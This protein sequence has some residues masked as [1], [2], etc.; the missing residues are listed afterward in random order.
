MDDFNVEIKTL[1]SEELIKELVS[2]KEKFNIEFY[3]DFD[4]IILLKGLIL[5]VYNKNKA[6]EKRV[7]ALEKRVYV[8]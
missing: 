8:K 1:A 4:N 2:D 6:L 5:D 7:L 3:T